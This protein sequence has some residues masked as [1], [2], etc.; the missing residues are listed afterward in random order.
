MTIE[1][2]GK[3]DCVFCEQAKQLCNNN[4]LEY[5]YKTFGI[6]FTK[7]EIL[8][9]FVGA[10]TFPQIKIDGKPIGGYQE[11]KEQVECR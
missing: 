8:A 10:K 7:E 3:E 4:G 1:I 5:T 9:E 11:L 2:W 6:D